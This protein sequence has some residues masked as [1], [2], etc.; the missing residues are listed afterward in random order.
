V[1]DAV[2]VVVSIG[3]SPIP[4]AAIV[5]L[6]VA[7]AGSANMVPN[8][9]TKVEAVQQLPSYAQHQVPLLGAALQAITFTK[10]VFPTLH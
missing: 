8:T 10:V 7:A 9:G 2:F 6:L 3:P 1:T 4:V 5:A